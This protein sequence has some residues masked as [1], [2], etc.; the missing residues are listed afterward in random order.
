MQETKS[1]NNYETLKKM[2]GIAMF[3]AL[4]YGVTMVFRIPVMFLTYDAKDAVLVIASFIYGPVASLPMSLIC[5][6]LEF[7]TIGDTGFWGFLMN[8]CSSFAYCFTA[9]IIYKYRRTFNGAIISLASA[10]VV[11]VGVML[12]LNLLITP[13]YTGANLETVKGLILPLL[14][15]FNVAKALMNTAF[16]MILYK[17]VALALKRA[18][19]IHT[20]MSVK[21]DKKSLLMLIIGAVALL[22]AIVM[23]IIIK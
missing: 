11:F 12:I 22:I 5:S 7:I 15:P 6:L 8:F 17:P 3:A 4:A 23:F 20:G 10:A 19:L 9:S 18:K 1:H 2:T 13:I 21:F 16:A 14:L